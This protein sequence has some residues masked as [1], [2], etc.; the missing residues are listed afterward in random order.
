MDLEQGASPE[1]LAAAGERIGSYHLCSSPAAWLSGMNSACVRIHH[2]VIDA[3][4]DIARGAE[5]TREAV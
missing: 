5:V 1:V 2:L 3:L 4:E